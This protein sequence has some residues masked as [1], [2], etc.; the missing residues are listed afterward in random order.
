MGFMTSISLNTNMTDNESDHVLTRTFRQPCSV[1][2]Y[3]CQKAF[4][5]TVD[6]KYYDNVPFC[7]RHNP[8]A[9]EKKRKLARETYR[10]KY[11]NTNASNKGA[12]KRELV[13]AVKELQETVKLLQEKLNIVQPSKE[14]KE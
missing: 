3:N 11:L 8:Y 1:C 10:A 14:D 2:S 5:G 6:G 7:P 4:T 9:V 13:L 12:T